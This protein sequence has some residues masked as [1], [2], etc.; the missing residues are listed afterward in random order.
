MQEYW[1]Q[2]PCPPPGNLPDSGI[3]PLSPIF[4]AL[5][6]EFFTANATWEAQCEVEATNIA[7]LLRSCMSEHNSPFLLSEVLCT[8]LKYA[9]KYLALLDNTLILLKYR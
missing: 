5:A 7:E 2:L 3:E 6:G 1:T 9:L 4:L 8:C